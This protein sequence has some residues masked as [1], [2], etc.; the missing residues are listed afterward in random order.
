MLLTPT[1]ILS[2]FATK[3]LNSGYDS[4]A[5]IPHFS[6]MKDIS[7]GA[8]RLAKAINNKEG[9]YLVG[10]YDA[11]G[12]SSCALNVSFFHD[13]GYPIQWLIPDRFMDGYGVS[14]KIIERIENADVVFTVDNGIVAHDAARVCKERNIDLIITDHHTPGPV[15]PDCYA[16]INPKQ[17]D[18]DYPFKEISGCFVAWLV[19]CAVK[20]ELGLDTDMGKYLDLV[21]LS[22]VTD[23][24]PLIGINRHVLKYGLRKINTMQRPFFK[25]LALSIGK[26]SFTYE[27]LGFQVGPRINAAGRLEHASLAVEALLSDENTAYKHVQLLSETNALRK[28]MQSE[29]SQTVMA[30]AQGQK[31]FIV[32]HSDDLHE[33]IVGILASKVAETFGYPTIIL[34]TAENGLLKGSG[35]S[36]GVVDMFELVNVN[37]S[38]LEKFGG[39]AGACGL[40]LKAENL[41][42]FI[43]NLRVSSRKLP[44]DDFKPLNLAIGELKPKNVNL[45]LFYKLEQF[46]PFGEGNPAPIF[47]CKKATVITSKAVG[48]EGDHA[49]LLLNWEGEEV[50][51]MAFNRDAGEYSRGCNVSFDYRLDLNNWNGNISLQYMPTG[52]V[53]TI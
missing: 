50:N 38:Y 11:D 19:C 4:I 34:S 24:M 10:D 15:I 49:R 21:A 42:L 51:I 7:K 39:H 17:A 40:S 20:Q 22:T 13:I 36:V 53:R 33:G 47:H 41:D 29:M 28:S 43:Q 52:E 2:R 12:V 23:V 1:D 27:D 9:I 30:L 46:A 16:V 31:D 6:I 3:N 37:N 18:C 26:E 44:L 8:K 25:E 32:V 48:K 45:D 35:R 5:D 14:P